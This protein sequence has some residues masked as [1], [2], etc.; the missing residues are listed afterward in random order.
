MTDTEQER[1]DNVILNEG[2]SGPSVGITVLILWPVYPASQKRSPRKMKCI[3]Y[4]KLKERKIR[5][6]LRGIVGNRITDRN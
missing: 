1:E 5:Q 2:G 6:N 4:L 3:E